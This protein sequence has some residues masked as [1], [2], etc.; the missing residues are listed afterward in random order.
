MVL[1][2]T[3]RSE[4]NLFDI[5]LQESG[6][7]GSVFELAKQNNSSITAALTPGLVLSFVNLPAST[8]VLR[9]YKENNLFPATG[10]ATELP[11]DLRQKEGIDY[12]AIQVDFKIQ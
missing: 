11:D 9:Y 10:N 3:V 12:W 6:G 1:K 4:Q 2:T 5:A 8:D 7:I